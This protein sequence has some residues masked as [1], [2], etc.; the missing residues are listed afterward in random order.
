MNRLI[1]ANLA[2]WKASRHRKPLILQGARQVGKTYVL[3]EFGRS[4]YKQVVYC[5]FESD[6]ALSEAFRPSLNP[7]RI[8]ELLRAYLGVDIAPAETLIIFDEI[9]ECGPA[10]TSLKYFHEDAPEYSIAAAGSLLGVTLAEQSSFPVGSVEFLT[11]GPLSFSEFVRARGRESLS[12]FVHHQPL[13]APLPEPVAGEL[14]RLLVQ[15]QVIGGM[16]EAVQRYLDTES[17]EQVRQIQDGILK[18]Y[19][20]DF[21]KHAPRAEVE[22][23]LAVW[24]AVPAVLGRENKKFTFAQIKAGARAAQYEQAITWLVQAGVVLRCQRI[25]TPKMPLR[26]HVDER[27]FKLYFNDVGLLCAQMR[28]SPALLLTPAKLLGEYSG[29]VAENFVAQELT[30]LGAYPLYYW[31]SSGEA[32]LDFMLESARAV[33]P[34][35][36]KAVHNL[37]S[38]SLTSYIAAHTPAL[39]LRTSLQNLHRSDTILNC[40]LYALERLRDLEKLQTSFADRAD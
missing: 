37:K 10:L 20:N 1:L 4:N 23:I 36:V 2:K 40:P 38:R 13:S 3:K 28:I 15:Y 16:P 33:V 27:A 34:L 12:D 39:A 25:K 24:D 35:E 5:N 31:T 19:V 11:L 21:A 29:V 6:P 30:A 22:A 17:I 9:Q 8:L 18:S 14:A 26:S 32:E 7:A